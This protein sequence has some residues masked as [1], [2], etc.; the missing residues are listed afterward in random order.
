MNAIFSILVFF[1]LAVMQ[2]V[3]L[4]SFSFFPSCFD[5]LIIAVLFLSLISTHHSMIIALI[6]I[7][8]VMD[9]ISGVPFFF[10]ILSYISIYLIVHLVKRMIFKQSIIFL[11]IIS[12]IA[13]LI[14][15]ALLLFSIFVRQEPG[16]TFRFDYFLLAKQAFWGLVLIPP[17]ISMLHTYRQNWMAIIKKMKKQMADT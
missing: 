9:S 6:V 5:L 2:A 16:T 13:V 15:H 11:I 4:P 10:H 8:C 3:I 7:G 17:C 12:L 1:F 14:Q